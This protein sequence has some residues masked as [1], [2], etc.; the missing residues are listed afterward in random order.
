MRGATRADDSNRVL[1]AVLQLAPNI[2]NDRWSMNFAQRFWIRRRAL[3]NDSR[4]EIANALELRRK[5][6]NRFPVRNLIGS[7][8]ADSFDSAKIG[9]LCRERAFRS[10]ENFEQ[11]AQPDRADRWQHVER[12][13]GFSRVHKFVA[14][15]SSPCSSAECRGRGQNGIS[16]SSGA[17]A[18]PDLGGGAADFPLVLAGLSSSPA[19]AG[20]A[21][22]LGLLPS[23]CIVSPMPRSLLRFWPLCLSSHVSNC[24]R[25]SIKTGRPFFKYSPAISARLAHKTT[26]TKVTS[27]RFSPLSSVYTRLTARPRSQTALPFGVYRIS[28]SRVK[29]PRRMTL[30]KLAMRPF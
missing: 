27:S 19:S 18:A 28:G 14:R 26:S 2:N 21:P 7:S 4:A 10:F 8:V 12:D 13:T 3:S 17:A 6:A 5:I 9:P 29:F 15:A 16:S 23:I 20:A 22:A 24:R 25:P 1:I 11:L 30:L